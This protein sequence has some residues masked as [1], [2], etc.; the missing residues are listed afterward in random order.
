MGEISF[1]AP[2]AS[3]KQTRGSLPNCRK[4]GGAAGRG[5]SSNARRYICG[6]LWIATDP[7]GTAFMSKPLAM[8]KVYS[9]L[10]YSSSS[11]VS[12]IVSC[13]RVSAAVRSRSHV[14]VSSTTLC[15]AAWSLERYGHT[16]NESRC[17]RRRAG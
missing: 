10:T 1:V 5:G 14:L 7:L 8:R 12:D 4:L 13:F 2:P 3:V 15:S 11:G 9:I 16:A 6:S 17:A